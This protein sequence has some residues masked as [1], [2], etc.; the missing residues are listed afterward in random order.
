[1]DTSVR[2]MPD[3]ELALLRRGVGEIAAGSERCGRCNRTPLVGERVH[4]YGKRLLCDLCRELERKPPDS[5]RLVHGPAFGTSIRI[6]DGRA[7]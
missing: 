3:I 4:V 7:A 6:I 1:M 5:S 2:Q